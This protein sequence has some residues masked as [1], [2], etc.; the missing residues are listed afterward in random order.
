MCGCDMFEC[1]QYTKLYICVCVRGC[2]GVYVCVMQFTFKITYGPSPV[3]K[4]AG[5]VCTQ[6]CV[7]LSVDNSQHIDLYVYG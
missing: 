3:S 4:Q 6:Q 5:T 1:L 7:Y 2:V